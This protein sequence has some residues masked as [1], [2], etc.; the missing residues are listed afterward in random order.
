M[1]LT[2]WTSVSDLCKYGASALAASKTESNNMKELIARV[3]NASSSSIRSSAA[4]WS[5]RAAARH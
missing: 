5:S 4:S 2:L 3:L 1:T